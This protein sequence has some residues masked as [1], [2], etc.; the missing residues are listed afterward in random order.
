[1]QPF[2]KMMV[3]AFEAAGVPWRPQSQSSAMLR[4]LHG[5][6][7]GTW[8]S[9]ACP[10]GAM[11]HRSKH[12]VMDLIPCARQ[13]AY[14]GLVQPLNRSFPNLVVRP[15]SLAAQLLWPTEVVGGSAG[16]AASSQRATGVEVVELRG[17]APGQANPGEAMNFELLGENWAKRLS[18]RY[19][20]RARRG[21]I[22]AAGA[23]GSPALLLRSG[24]GPPESLG[25]LRVP[26]RLNLSSVGQGLRDR[27]AVVAMVVTN[28]ECQLT[29]SRTDDVPAL[30]AYF[31]FSSPNG[32]SGDDGAGGGPVEAEL[33][34]VDGCMG[35][36]ESFSLRFIMQRTEKS[37]R[38]HVVSPH[39]LVATHAE[40]HA[41]RE[42]LR[43]A[44]AMLRW[45]HSNILK[46][47]AV[48]GEVVDVMP[49]AHILGDDVFLE[50]FIR[51]SAEWYLHPSGS[52]AYGAVDEHL[53]VQGTANVHVA[54]ASVLPGGL[55][56]GHPDASIRMLGE[57][58][59]QQLLVDVPGGVLSDPT[60]LGSEA[61]R[62]SPHAFPLQS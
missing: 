8:L 62:R 22:L 17:E 49:G 46:H 13:S 51:D 60:A 54:D 14:S 36:Y 18:R 40:L 24:V 16:K 42:D 56:S 3:D 21:I 25:E 1:M 50:A 37:G 33:N 12:E 61:F 32:P 9:L 48:E 55:P 44:G 29:F 31:N 20:A 19:V 35:G 15:S 38:L 52:L 34:V 11:G 57:T 26:P 59:A 5:V 23:M 47:S 30:F 2:L 43:R 7:G 4:S 58:L 39:P 28:R 10:K 6:H 41:T 27:V 53:R 45:F